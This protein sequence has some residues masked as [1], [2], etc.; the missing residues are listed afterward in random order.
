MVGVSL[1]AKALT[2]VS[3]LILAGLLLQ[4]E[5]GLAALAISVI[6]IT[7]V[8]QKMGFREMLMHRQDR[9]H[10]WMNPAIWASAVGGLITLVLIVLFAPFAPW[11]FSSDREIVTLVLV[12]AVGASM[13]G[14]IGSFEAMLS[15]QLRFKTVGALQTVESITRVG[16]Q[17]GLAFSGFGAMSIILARSLTWVLHAVALFVVSKPQLKRRPELA[18]WQEAWRDC[19]NLFITNSSFVAIRQGDYFL[20]GVFFS[21][22]IV[23]A[24]YF[25]FNLSTQ[26]IMLIAQSMSTV[27]AA[28]LSKLKSDPVRQRRAFV[29]VVSLISFVAV[30]LLVMQAVCAEPLLKGLYE[31]KWND[32]IVPL[33]ILSLAACWSAV[34]WNSGAMFAATGR[35]REQRIT[36]LVGGV[37]FVVS[38]GL[39]AWWGSAVTVAVAVLVFRSV[40][41][42]IQIGIAASGRASVAI[43][44]VVCL[45]KP[46]AL[47]V[48]AAVPAHFLGIAVS[49]GLGRFFADVVADQTGWLVTVLG[50]NGHRGAL[51]ARVVVT[52]AAIGLLY[53]VLARLVL[54]STYAE[55]SA[56]LRTILPDRVS[57]RVPGWL[58]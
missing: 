45:L 32:A 31:D 10:E 6:D 30:P 50:E 4:T 44:S 56:R 8:V 24:Y 22:A 35:F 1:F 43:H 9:V 55:F 54:R 57:S 49:D 18:K 11:V 26:A 29:N 42:P 2:S 3:Q 52:S 58:I 40:Y 25:A 37:A 36:A 23:G 13:V 19:L 51:L 53:Y 20:L 17:I 14:F 16:L 46:L 41:I 15:I 28:G 33:Q 34:G 47:C 21:E 7:G 39:A 48:L 12:A 38:I 27:L 5:F